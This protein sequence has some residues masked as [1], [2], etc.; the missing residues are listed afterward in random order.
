MASLSRQAS[1]RSSAYE[2]LEDEDP[3]TPLAQL[4]QGLTRRLSQSI[5][6]RLRDV[7]KAT[8]SLFSNE[9]RSNSTT[10][11]DHLEHQLEGL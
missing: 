8:A 4:S 7:Q 3:K 10:T 11:Q 5:N 9:D 2:A 1:N 6:A